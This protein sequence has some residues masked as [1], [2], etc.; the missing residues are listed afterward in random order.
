MIK[1]KNDSLP[2][3]LKVAQALQ[4][5]AEEEGWK[6]NYRLPGEKELSQQLG[7]SRATVREALSALEKDGLILRRQGVGTFL[8]KRE[9][10]LQRGMKGFTQNIR[11]QGLE[12]GTKNRSLHREP[13]DGFLAAELGINPGDLVWVIKRTR[14]ANEQPIMYSV[15]KV[16]VFLLENHLEEADFPESLFGLLQ[17]H[18]IRLTHA[19]TRAHP[20]LPGNFLK[21]TLELS[22][23][24]PLL[25]VEETYVDTQAR[26]VLYARS[27]FRTDK[28]SFRVIRQV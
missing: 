3:Y 20:I 7:V 23:D 27:Y 8:V 11:D 28:Y 26:P 18:G 12:P 4:Q 9:S 15:D 5:T 16:P 19:I 1:V 14:T 21:Q 22:G 25:F 24:Q 2:L 10:P 13:A 17:E 6:D